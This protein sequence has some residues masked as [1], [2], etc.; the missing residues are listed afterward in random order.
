MCDLV[1][2]ITPFYLLY[3]I[4]NRE[5][6][7]TVR[8]RFASVNEAECVACGSCIK[9]CPK[10]AIRVPNGVSAIVDL[11]KCVGCGL[12]AKECPASV[13]EIKVH[14]EEAMK[15]QVKG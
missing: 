2:D 4:K 13:I 12:C 14:Q 5:V 7:M 10:E 6:V 15:E 11:L 8:R 3:S 1:T 9:V